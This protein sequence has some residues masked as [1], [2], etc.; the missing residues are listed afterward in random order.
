MNHIF[1]IQTE[2]IMSTTGCMTTEGYLKLLQD[3]WIHVD[4]GT[5][6]DFIEKNLV[7]M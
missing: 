5:F 3:I 6:N 7:K 2:G 4:N 1:C